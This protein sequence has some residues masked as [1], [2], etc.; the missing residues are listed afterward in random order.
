VVQNITEGSKEEI[1]VYGMELLIYDMLNTIIILLIAP[2][3]SIELYQQIL[4]EFYDNV[5]IWRYGKY[6]S[7]IVRHT[8]QTG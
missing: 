2:I 6:L 4:H 5:Y 8:L 1:Y 7:W 3:F